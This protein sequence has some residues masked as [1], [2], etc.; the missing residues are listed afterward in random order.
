M[1]TALEVEYDFDSEAV[2]H[3]LKNN[4]TSVASDSNTQNLNNCVKFE[5]I[6]A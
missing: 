3:R 2:T 5:V 1:F 6:P 4:S